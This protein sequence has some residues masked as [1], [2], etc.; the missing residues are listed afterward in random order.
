MEFRLPTSRYPQPAQMAA[1]FRAILERMRAVPGVESVAL[2]RAVPFSG[3][4]GSSTYEVDGRPP[5]APGRE[6]L[7]QTNIVSTDYFRTMGIPILQGR[8]FEA[9]DTADATAVAVVS[10]TFARTVWPGQDPLGKRFRLKDTPRW[11]TVVGVAGD[12]RH[13]SF[14]ETPMP[15]AYTTHDQDPRIFACVVA[16]TTGDPMAAAAPIRQA[17]WSVDA[18]Q[19]VWRVRSMESILAASRGPARAMSILIAI[20]AAV[21]P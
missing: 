8:D 5:A 16:R 21:A 19:P 1:F 4:G 15:Q 9:R 14:A 11:L 17:I 12:I 2:V 3:N 6:P 7:T 10:G 13:G 18:Q 20:F